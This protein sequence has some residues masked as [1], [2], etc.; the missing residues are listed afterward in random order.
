MHWPSHISWRS[1]R[2]VFCELAYFLLAVDSSIATA[3]YSSTA[4]PH[5]LQINSA[6]SFFP[7][8]FWAAA[9]AISWRGEV[10]FLA[11]IISA[12]S[13]A[14]S[15][16]FLDFMP[17][18]FRRRLLLDFACSVLG[19]GALCRSGWSFEWSLFPARSFVVYSCAEMYVLSVR[20]EI[21]LDAKSV[22]KKLAD[23]EPSCAFFLIWAEPCINGS[24][25]KFVNFIKL[26]NFI[27]PWTTG[28]YKLLL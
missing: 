13:Y 28:V 15:R 7:S 10:I 17:V 5:L 24:Y 6:R 21:H 26:G 19:G 14:E 25:F 2:R 9:K 12:T 8:R 4:F 27:I 11:R 18:S 20:T 1:W 23:S 3:M 22:V 16:H